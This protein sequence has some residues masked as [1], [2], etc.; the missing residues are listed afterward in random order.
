MQRFNAAIA[1]YVGGTTNSW[2][3]PRHWTRIK[4][5]VNG[6]C[7]CPLPVHSTDI[8]AKI[9]ARFYD[10][11]D[12]TV[13]T[14]SGYRPSVRWCSRCRKNA[15]QLFKDEQDYSPPG[16]VQLLGG[17]YENAPMRRT[18]FLCFAYLILLIF[19]SCIHLPLPAALPTS[20]NYRAVSVDLICFR[21]YLFFF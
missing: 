6:F 12:R 9:P 10:M 13:S 17:Y 8:S 11:F 4:R 14:A 16:K 20:I 15:D 2:A 5:E 18:Y 7:E 1:R 3:C 21:I 19:T